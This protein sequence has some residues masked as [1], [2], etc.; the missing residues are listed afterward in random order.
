MIFRTGNSRTSPS[1]S[2]PRGGFTLIELIL[3]MAMMLIVLSLAGASLSGF[4]KSRTLEAEARRFLSLT[5]YA[6]SR[7][8]AES[9]PMILWVDLRR[10]L[11]GVEPEFSFSLTGDRVV[12]YLMGDD[13]TIQVITTPQQNARSTRGSEGGRFA[14]ADIQM[15]FSPDGFLGELN[16]QQIVLLPQSDSIPSSRGSGGI[17]IAPNR[18]ASGYEIQPSTAY[19]T[20]R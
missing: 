13:L 2:R 7:A 16:P 20:R 11:Y 5:R 9:T 19:A 4:F 12:E 8:A 6:Q 15:R 10:R 18:T 17:L 3:V 1:G 14:N